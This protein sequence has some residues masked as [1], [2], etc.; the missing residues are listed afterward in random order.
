MADAAKRFWAW[1]TVYHYFRLFKIDGTWQ[2]IHDKLRERVRRNAGKKPTPSA[3]VL[4][5][6]SVKTSAPQKGRRTAR[7]QQSRL[8]AANITSA[9]IPAA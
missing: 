7:M 3:G 5:S 9:S 2:L 1:S 6:Q 4:D 8:S